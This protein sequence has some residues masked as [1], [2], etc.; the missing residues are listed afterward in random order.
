MTEMTDQMKTTPQQLLAFLEAQNIPHETATHAAVFTVEESAALL[1]SLPPGSPGGPG[2]GHC[3]SLFVKTKKGELFLVVMSGEKRLDIKALGEKLGV[4]RLSFCSPERLLE[5]LGVTP[6]SVTPFSLINDP[7]G[8]VQV[9]LDKGM[10]E[11]DQLHYHPLINSMTTLISRDGLY[12]FLKAV[13]HDP[14]ELEL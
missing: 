8:A 11:H 2:G 10:L 14:I 13:K 6:G 7:D 12:Q 3:K 9:V 4:G 1:A 5:H